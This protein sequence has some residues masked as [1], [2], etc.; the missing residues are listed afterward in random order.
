MIQSFKHKGLRELFEKGKTKKFPAEHLKKI[1]RLLD[2]VAAAHSSEDFN[3]PGKRLHKLKAPPYVDF[4]SLDVTG[5][6][7]LIFKFENGLATDVNYID[8]H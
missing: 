2:F 4:Y 8:T 1:K 3:L 6:Y 5:N 7:R